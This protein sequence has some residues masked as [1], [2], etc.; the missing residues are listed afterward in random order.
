MA[1]AGIS[2]SC[3]YP[4]A[5]EESLI[6]IGKSGC[7]CTEIFFN[8]ISELEESFIRNL[9]AIKNNYNLNIVSIHP[10]MSFAETY[11]LF[12][13]YERRYHDSIDFYK[14]FFEITNELGAKYFIFHG[15][16]IPGSIN[17]KE[18]IERFGEL[19]KI[20]KQEGINVCQENV[21]NYISQSPDFIK[22]MADT[23]GDDFSIVLDIKQA[24]RA[25]YEPYSFLSA[26]GKHIRHVH[27]SDYNEDSTCI[28]PLEGYFDFRKFFSSM[29]ESGYNGSYMIELYDTSYDHEQQIYDSY[30]K[31]NKILVDY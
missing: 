20:G 23:I 3:F 22:T 18:Y 2:S 27:I 25:C 4:L 31:I 30:N 26:A 6:K 1:T 29:K 24:R 10:F 11:F 14:R 7:T 9:I 21:V 8:S 12:S 15:M 28:P 19:I 13:S 17:N 5:T 16:K